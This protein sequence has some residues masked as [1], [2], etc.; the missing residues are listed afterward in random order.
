MSVLEVVGDLSEL[1]APAL[2]VAF[3]DWVDAGAAASGAARHIAEG[4]RLLARFDGDA[5]FD[6]RS[7]RPVLDIVDGSYKKLELPE[8]RLVANRFGERDVLVLTGPEPDYRWNEFARSVQEI[9]RSAGV[10]RHVSLGAIPA[11]VPHTASTPVMTTASSPD[12]LSESDAQTEGFLR[13]PA[14]AVSLIEWTLSNAGIPAVGFWAQVPHYLSP[15]PPASIAL[16]RRVESHLGVTIGVGDM[17][18]EAAALRARLDEMFSSRPEAK[19]YLEQLE[20]LTG[21]P[22]VPG[23]DEIAAE[24][25]R[26]LRSQS[27]ESGPNPLSP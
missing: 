10:V 2:V 11:A 7:H 16:I 17:E 23:A 26:F 6:F 25:E 19:E 14:A 18:G 24:V 12:L 3:Q 4:G 9:S 22:E 20:Q 27:G 13:V 8:M 15:Y 21:Q 5:L 1:N